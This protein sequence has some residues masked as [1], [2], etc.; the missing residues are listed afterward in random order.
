MGLLCATRR[1][2]RPPPSPVQLARALSTRSTGHPTSLAAAS[3]PAADQWIF[4]RTERPVRLLAIGRITALFQLGRPRGPGVPDPR[5]LAAP[6]AWGARTPCWAGRSPMPFSALSCARRGRRPRGVEPAALRRRRHARGGRCGGR[7]RGDRLRAGRSIEVE[8]QRGGAAVLGRPSGLE[9]LYL[10]LLAT[11]YSLAAMSFVLPSRAAPRPCS[12]LW[13]AWLRSARG[14]RWSP[15]R[16]AAGRTRRR[17]RPRAQAPRAGA[18]PRARAGGGD[19]HRQLHACRPARHR[20][21]GAD[22]LPR[23]GVRP[24]RGVL[25]RGRLARRGAASPAG[26]APSRLR[27]APGWGSLAPTRWR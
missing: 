19:L 7:G 2:L 11:G 5:W 23:A 17:A 12:S 20:P 15:R 18:R 24:G 1:G 22:R 8:G 3:S 26:G 10:V 21:R 6:V 16:G 9:L 27:S 4:I 14:Y 25:R 13:P